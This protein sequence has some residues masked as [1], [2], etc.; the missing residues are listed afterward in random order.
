MIFDR[1]MK[2]KKKN[3]EMNKTRINILILLII[4][5]AMLLY[6]ALLN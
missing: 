3:A 5:S 1:M 6:T 4:R 2:G